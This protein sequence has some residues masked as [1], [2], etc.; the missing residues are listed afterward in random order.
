MHARRTDSKC[1]HH[2]R[3]EI[4]RRPRGVASGKRFADALES[5]SSS[6]DACKIDMKPVKDVTFS[7]TIDV[8]DANHASIANS[9]NQD[10]PRII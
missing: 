7:K 4:V 10:Q 1:L 9:L 2:Q 5:D 3:E 6:N 8:S